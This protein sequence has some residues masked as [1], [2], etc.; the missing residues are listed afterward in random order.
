MVLNDA[1]IG[2][3]SVIGTLAGSALFAHTSMQVV[4]IISAVA[5]LLAFVYIYFVNEESLKVSHTSLG[6]RYI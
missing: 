3:G 4:F 1:A 5:L 2:A 6:V